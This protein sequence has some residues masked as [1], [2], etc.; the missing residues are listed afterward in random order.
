MTEQGNRIADN[1]K[2]L[3]LNHGM[4]VMEA[5]IPRLYYGKLRDIVMH[6]HEPDEFDIW[7]LTKA[8]RCTEAE[9]LQPCEPMDWSKIS[10]NIKARLKER[11]RSQAWLSNES[12]IAYPTI[13]Q[14]CSGRSKKP[15]PVNLMCI[16]EVLGCRT[17]D[18]F[19]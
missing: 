5:S 7:L 1:T 3:L 10:A 13:N 4:T 17:E 9:L 19:R 8:L 15:R 6:N 16:A 18:L 14:I 12:G 11:K 2:R